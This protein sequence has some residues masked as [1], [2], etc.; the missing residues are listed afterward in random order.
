MKSPRL[1]FEHDPRKAAANLRK[2]KVSFREAITVFDDPLAATFPDELHSEDE[3]RFIT[4]GLSSTQRLLFVSHLED[5]DR[6]RLIG[7]RSVTAAEKNAYE[8]LQD[9]S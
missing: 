1:I 4:I 7:A 5:E 8:E 3:D 6:V 2:H 9:R